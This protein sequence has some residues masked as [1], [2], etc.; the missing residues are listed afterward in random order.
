MGSIL[1]LFSEGSK[2]GRRQINAVDI[3]GLSEQFVVYWQLL[4]IWIAN[5]DGP[6]SIDE[7]IVSPDGLVLDVIALQVAESKDG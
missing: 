2:L 6:L 3:S 7:D 5:F 4:C 1:K